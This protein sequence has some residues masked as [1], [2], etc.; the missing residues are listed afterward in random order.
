MNVFMTS[1]IFIENVNR[2]QTAEWVAIFLRQF[3]VTEVVSN[4]VSGH[5]MQL[6]EFYVHLISYVP[7]IS[8]G[9]ALQK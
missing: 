8:Q 1:R 5:V 3:W 6:L 9:D 2:Y 7:Y 4:V